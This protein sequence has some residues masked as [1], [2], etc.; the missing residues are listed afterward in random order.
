MAFF[1][2]LTPEESQKAQ[3]AVDKLMDVLRDAYGDEPMQH[4]ERA[5]YQVS[6]VVAMLVG[7]IGE[8]Y[9]IA[10]KNRNVSH[11]MMILIV[12]HMMDQCNVTRETM[13]EIANETGK[14]A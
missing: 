4:D 7:C 6:K 10:T 12:G 8:G 1:F 2:K 9:T 5:T 13:L 14:S 11:A 3:D